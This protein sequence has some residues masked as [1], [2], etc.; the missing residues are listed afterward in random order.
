MK[1]ESYLALLFQEMKQKKLRKKNELDIGILC[2]SY[3][4][5]IMYTGACRAT[6]TSMSALES[7]PCCP[8]TPAYGSKQALGKEFKGIPGVFAASSVL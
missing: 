8:V 3:V 5:F 1:A 7:K 2:S 4:T 6:G